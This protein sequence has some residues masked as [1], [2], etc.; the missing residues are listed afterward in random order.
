MYIICH[1]CSEVEALVLTH[2]SVTSVTIWFWTSGVQETRTS[3][4][5]G[6]SHPAS[7][8]HASST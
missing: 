6:C 1:Y 8:E 3:H 2:E 5:D 4:A 7:V